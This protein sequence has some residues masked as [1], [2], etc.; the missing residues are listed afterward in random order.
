MIK[1]V[2]HF[3]NDNHEEDEIS[4]TFYINEI[5]KI[6][7][8]DSRISAFIISHRDSFYLDQ[9]IKIDLIIKYLKRSK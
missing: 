3:M 6:L 1:D 9:L 2:S 7:A 8:P 5:S 4:K